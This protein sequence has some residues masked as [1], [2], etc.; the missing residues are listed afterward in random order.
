MAIDE[1]TVWATIMGIVI[2]LFGVS[3]IPQL[4]RA[5]GQTKA[6]YEDSN[7]CGLYIVNSGQRT[8]IS[9]SCRSV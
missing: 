1:S 7:I 3:K 6:E 8:L 9:Y 5:N 4:A 2:F